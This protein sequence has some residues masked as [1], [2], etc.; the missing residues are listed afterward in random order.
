MHLA[1]TCS[2]K[3]KVPELSGSGLQKH[4]YQWQDWVAGKPKSQKQSE[5]KHPELSVLIPQ[6]LDQQR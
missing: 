2:D 3:S 1:L 4:N 5:K 6:S